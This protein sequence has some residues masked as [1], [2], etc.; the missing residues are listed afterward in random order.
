MRTDQATPAVLITHFLHERSSDRA[1]VVQAH[2]VKKV[3]E[4]RIRTQ[5]VKQ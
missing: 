5:T 3:L 1:L 2:A 4:A